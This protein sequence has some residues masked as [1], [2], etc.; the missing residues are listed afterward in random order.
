MNTHTKVTS[1]TRRESRRSYN[2]PNL[3]DC[4]CLAMH[5][6]AIPDGSGMNDGA[7]ANDKT[8]F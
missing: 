7:K 5:T 4:G 2:T 8:G 3:I 6:Q 1:H